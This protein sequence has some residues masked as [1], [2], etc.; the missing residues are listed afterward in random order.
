MEKNKEQIEDAVVVEKT[1]VEETAEYDGPIE[2]ERV[3][4]ILSSERLS[5]GRNV[6][7]DTVGH[8]YNFMTSNNEQL[9]KFKSLVEEANNSPKKKRKVSVNIKEF[10]EFLNG[11]IGYM[12]RMQGVITAIQADIDAVDY[13]PEKKEDK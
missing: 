3:D 10:S 12:F 6:L 13:K 11:V 2:K 9:G 5:I 1:A 7:E 8:I 4:R